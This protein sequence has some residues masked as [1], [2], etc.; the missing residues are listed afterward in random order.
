MDKTSMEEPN[1]IEKRDY[2]NALLSQGACNLSGI[3]NSFTE[4]LNRI[5]E[6]AQS[7]GQGTD[8]VNQHPIC[9]LFA[10]QIKHLSSGT[11][12]SDAYK[13]CTD[14]AEA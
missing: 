8:F 4:I 2:Q 7:V 14:K 1:M 11:D 3:V 6:E 13:I 5:R 10:E 9:V 12:Y